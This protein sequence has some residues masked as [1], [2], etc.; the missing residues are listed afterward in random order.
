[1]VGVG[2]SFTNLTKPHHLVVSLEVLTLPI[3]PLAEKAPL[4][5]SGSLY[6]LLSP[7]PLDPRLTDPSPPPNHVIRHTI[8]LAS[9]PGASLIMGHQNPSI[10]K[11]NPPLTIQLQNP[12]IA[13]QGKSDVTRP[14]GPGGLESFAVCLYVQM[15]LCFLVCL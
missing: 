6:F 3:H 14:P 8:P 7:N 5:Q 12:F 15:G 10:A 2:D 13:I 11:H 9:L 1:M 4:S